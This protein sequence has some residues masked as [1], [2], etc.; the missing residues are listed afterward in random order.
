MNQPTDTQTV[1][2]STNIETDMQTAHSHRVSHRVNKHW[3][4]HA[5]SSQPQS[6]SQQTLTQTDSSQGQPL[7]QQTLEQT[8]RHRQLTGSITESAHTETD[9]Q[10]TGSVTEPTNNETDRQT[11]SPRKILTRHCNSLDN[12]TV[13][14]FRQPNTQTDLITVNYT[15]CIPRKTWRH[16]GSQRHGH[17]TLCTG[18]RAG[19]NCWS[20]QPV[21]PYPH[22]DKKSVTLA[23][24]LPG[25]YIVITITTTVIIEYLLCH[26]V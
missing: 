10:L 25:P 19:A 23:L 1:T 9:R 13:K 21:A 4:R 22:L 18:R 15:P 26:I 5:N 2:E 6:L 7:S 20:L 11:Q 12:W 16:S 3:N 17:H 14:T 8:D 24:K